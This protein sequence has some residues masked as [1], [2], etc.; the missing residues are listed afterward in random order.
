MEIYGEKINK[1]IIS[2]IVGSFMLCKFEVK[3]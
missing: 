2:K 1:E 3:D